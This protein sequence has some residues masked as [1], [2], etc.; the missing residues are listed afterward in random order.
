M[1]LTDRQRKFA[2]A[3]I[4]VALAAAGIYLTL[5]TNGGETEPS[6]QRPATGVPVG[7]APPATTPPG[8][9]SS[10]AP[11]S[12]DIYRLLPFSQR[13]F[14]GAADLA[15]R[16][17]A[18]YGTYRFD[19]DPKAYVQRLQGMV[20]EQLRT[21]LERGSS[22][23]GLLEERKAEQAS[24]ESTATID[25]IR[26]IEANSVIFLVTGRQELTSAGR[27][28]QE[29]QRYAVTVSRDGGSW[30]IYAFEPADAG[31]AGD[32]G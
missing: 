8:I 22:A 6:A 13:D 21:E 12:F 28:S 32:T 2:F 29:S 5:P 1:D 19:E 9:E 10:I 18:A 24:A 17:T 25:S 3:G 11:D 4:V 26:D 27:R 31:Q 7:P 20:T 14:A 16:F 15:Q 23:P 30:R